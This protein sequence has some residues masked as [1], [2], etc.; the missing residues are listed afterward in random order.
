MLWI[1]LMGLSFAGGSF[2]ELDW[3]DVLR[4]D[5]DVVE[6]D[7]AVA[8]GVIDAVA[9]LVGLGH[10]MQQPEEIDLEVGAGAKVEALEQL[11]ALAELEAQAGPGPARRALAEVGDEAAVEPKRQL[12]VSA[13]GRVEPDHQLD[14][15]PAPRRS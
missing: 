4:G 6:Q 11:A 15:L 12:A 5:D 1:V 7:G 3:A 10:V 2:P 13:A 8:G 9:P 14:A